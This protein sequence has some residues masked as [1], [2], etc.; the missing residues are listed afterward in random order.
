M[1]ES[2]LNL[3]ARTADI[4]FR[5]P[6]SITGAMLWGLILYFIC[7]P[8]FFRKK[9]LTQNLGIALLF[10]Y[11]AALLQAN[12]CLRI[13]ATAKSEA[14]SFWQA[15]AKVEW[16]PFF[17]SS[18]GIQ[19]V[20]TTLLNDFCVLIPVGFLAPLTGSRTNFSK[21]LFLSMLCG[22]S[23]EILQLIANVSVPG[24]MHI[25]STGEAILSATGCLI[26]YLFLTL[27]R[28]LPI[29]RHKARHYAHPEQAI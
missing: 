11:T 7:L 23:L 25:V 15:A 9:G 21:M 12:G 5:V 26:G 20:R 29:H 28:K 24:T 13:P 18:V 27:L 6:L 4:L 16:N 14:F 8:L 10:L 1:Q 2:F 17:I 22:A 19:D 3:P